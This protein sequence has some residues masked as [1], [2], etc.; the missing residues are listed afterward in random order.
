[1]HIDLS[2]SELPAGLAY[3]VLIIG[4]GPAGGAVAHALFDSGIR[5]AVVESGEEKPHPFYDGLRAVESEGITIKD[6]S[7]ER[8][9]GGTSTTWAALTSPLDPI[10]FEKRPWIPYSGW[11]IEFKDIKPFYEKAA[12]AFEFP[13]LA[14]FY[15]DAWMGLSGENGNELNWNNLEEKLFM[16]CNPPSNFK[17]VFA[18]AYADSRLDL[19]TGATVTAITGDGET[20]DAKSV[21]LQNRHHVSYTVSA[22]YLVLACG[23]IENARLLLNSTFACKAGLGNDKDQVGRF[24]MN[25]PKNNYGQIKPFRQTS[26]QYGYLHFL[27]LRHPYSVCKGMHLRA[28]Y[29]RKHHLLNS[30]IRLH[31]LFGWSERKSVASLL[32]Y[33]KKSKKSLGMVKRLKQRRPM[34]VLVDDAAIGDDTA[35]ESSRTTLRGHAEMLNAILFDM[36]FVAD[37]LY[38]RIRGDKQL[39]MGAIFIRNFMEMEPRPENRVS[40]SSFTDIFGMP[41]PRV[42]HSLS[43]L[44]KRSLI[45][46][47]NVLKVEAR[48]NGLGMVSSDLH[49]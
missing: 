32:Y 44:D 14:H 46:L 8:V 24:F 17:T 16:A 21:R 40:L 13:Q 26:R 35:A 27:A 47:P 37:Y 31:P 10:D 18:D 12:A 38:H 11:P 9:L 3:D 30:Y 2:R 39:M 29:Q 41:L 49:Q 34:G 42:S 48:Q 5:C 36:P 45:A 28:D 20:G 15:D 7:R 4:S 23:G 25:H 6:Y 1:V 22:R 43:T 33:L 19:F